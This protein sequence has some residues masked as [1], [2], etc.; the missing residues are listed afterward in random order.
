MHP[1][2]FSSRAGAVLIVAAT[3]FNNSCTV[4]SNEPSDS[5]DGDGD[6][7]G[8]GTGG[9]GVA[10]GGTFTGVGGTGGPA[11]V[12]GTGTP[13][14]GTAGDGDGDGLLGGYHTNN[15]WSGFAFAFASGAATI[16]PDNFENMINVDGPYCVSGSVPASSDYKNIAAVGVHTNQLKQDD[17]EV[18]TLVPQG[19]ALA[20]D[21]H[22]NSGSQTL[23]VQLEGPNAVNDA[24]QRWC[25]NVTADGSGNINEPIPWDSFNTQCWSGGMGVDYAGQ[26]IARVIIYVPDPGLA[27]DEVTLRPTETF[28]FCLNDIGPSGDIESIGSGAIVANC[29][30]NVTWNNTN[31]SGTSDA[32]SNGSQYGAQSNYWNPDGGAHSLTLLSSVGFTMTQQGCSRTGAEPCSFP[33]VFIGTDFN[34]ETKTSGN[35]LPIQLSSINSVD[36]CVGWSSNGTPVS[37]QYNVAYDVWLAANSGATYA[38]EFLMV[39]LRTPTEYGPAGDP[40]QNGAYIG[41]QVWTVWK[42]PNHENKNVVSYI[43]P[44]TRADGQAYDFDLADFIGHA[45]DEGYLENPNYYLI[46][47]MAGLEIWNG[48][49]GASIDGFRASAN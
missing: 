1:L 4:V 27:P 48:A 33:S 39:W 23:R 14:G 29:G 44:N 25:S 42:G 6:G 28:D 36:T 31:L 19:D 41:D 49:Q 3:L 40:V 43:A 35:G 24:T 5:G 21:I 17:A 45:L 26:E 12:G 15:N 9:T 46:S 20:V 2:Q 10:T 13:T 32:I 30:N 7:D 22:I 8:F 11:G 38:D 37:D 16:T 34:G 47:V 18:K